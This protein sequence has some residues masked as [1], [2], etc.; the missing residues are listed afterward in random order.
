MERE[1][2]VAHAA[3]M[4]ERLLKGLET[5]RA[6]PAVGDVRG[7]GLM[8]AVELVQDKN[9]REAFPTSLKV[10]PRVYTAGRERGVLYRNRG[11]VLEMAPP[12]IVTE[13]QIDQIIN[14]LGESIKEV[15]EQ[16]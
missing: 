5:L 6:L 15:T 9:T 2:L 10:G 8:A 1:D 3:E 7:L 14:V 16:S 12:L 13:G 4:G 11:D